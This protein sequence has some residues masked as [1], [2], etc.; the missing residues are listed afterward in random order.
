MSLNSVAPSGTPSRCGIWMPY[1]TFANAI[2]R[3]YDMS[4]CQPWPASARPIGLP[5]STMLDRIIT[6]GRPGSW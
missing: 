4:V 3:L 6:C 2:V 5:F 1:S